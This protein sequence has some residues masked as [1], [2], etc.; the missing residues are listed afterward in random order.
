MSNK[1]TNISSLGKEIL[2]AIESQRLTKKY[3][4]S[5]LG[6]SR[7]TLDNW[8]SGATAPDHNELEAMLKILGIDDKEPP[9]FRYQIS[10]GDYVGLHKLAWAEFQ[11][12]L[13]HSRKLL[14]EIVG[15]NTKLS[16]SVADLARTL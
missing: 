15:N 16:D 13:T 12:T 3:V 2:Q 8:I 1:L 4:Y 6:I 9:S 14:S 11:E 7:G 10:E 5:K